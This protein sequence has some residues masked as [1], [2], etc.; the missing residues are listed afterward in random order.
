MQQSAP[1]AIAIDSWEFS[2]RGKASHAA[3][4]PERGI[5]AL[6]AVNL[7]FAG[8]SALRQQLKPDV[9]IH[10]IVTDGGAAVNVIPESAAC[11]F[12]VR[13]EKREYLD[14]ASRRVIGCARG[15]P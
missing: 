5:N 11:R 4:A 1:H 14:E 8:I 10:G 3:A 7:T 6:D 9:R 2:F 15:R 12:Y 13:S